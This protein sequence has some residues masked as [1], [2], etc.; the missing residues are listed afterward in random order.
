[1]RHFNR[2]TDIV[3]CSLTEIL[4]SAADPQAALQEIIHE[5]EE[6]VA[7]ANRSVTT[8]QASAERIERELEEHRAQIEQWT[9]KARQE[10][11]AGSE[12]AA[13][14]ALM[15][16]SEVEDVVAGLEQQQQAA[17]TTRDHLSTMQR[18][19]EA[20]LAEAQRRLQQLETGQ[21]PGEASLHMTETS[22]LASTATPNEARKQQIE[23]ELDALK[24]ELEQ[25]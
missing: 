9:D 3:T 21:P 10:L 5:M 7:G 24:K 2:L 15:R 19:V 16:K 4:S 25:E 23:A 8:A 17:I 20:R 12:D 13:R 18:A 11:S 1:M 14:L 22:D 6:G